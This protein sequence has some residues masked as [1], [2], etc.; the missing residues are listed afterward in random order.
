MS[1]DMYLH[2]GYHHY[3][4]SESESEVAQLCQTLCDPMDCPTRFLSP[5]DFPGKN[6]RM[7]YHFLLH[8]KSNKHINISITSKSVLC[9][10][11]FYDGKG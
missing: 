11:A 2:P 9:P 7:G 10:S 5:W 6:T 3:N 4:K 8:N 1:L